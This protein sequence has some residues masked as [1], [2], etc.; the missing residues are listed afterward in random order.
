[1]FIHIA[2]AKYM[3]DYVL[4]IKFDNGVEGEVDLSAELWGEMFEPLRN[5]EFFRRFHVDNEINT[6]VWDNGAD[7]APDFLHSL[8]LKEQAA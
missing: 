5:V 7:M 1:M 2:E 8:L 3:R 4:W 6:I